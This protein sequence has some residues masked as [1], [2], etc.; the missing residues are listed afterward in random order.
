MFGKRNITQVVSLTDLAEFIKQVTP[1]QQQQPPQNTITI[2]IGELH[3]HQAGS[4][5]QQL[6]G[7]QDRMELPSP[8]S[9]AWPDPQESGRGMKTF[10]YLDRALTDLLP[11]AG[12]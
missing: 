10:D 7:N 6:P 2:Y 1:Q 9:V 8:G 4:G 12:R 3:I 5:Y 11:K